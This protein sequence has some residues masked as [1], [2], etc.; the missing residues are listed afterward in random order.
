MY[1]LSTC[2][3]H[4]A[5]LV[6]D[7]SVPYGVI[8]SMLEMCILITSL[9]KILHASTYAMHVVIPLYLT[10]QSS[11]GYPVSSLLL[12]QSHTIGQKF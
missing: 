6:T 8:L 10:I 1:A 3:L 2:T 11:S 4:L 7:N 9:I 5:N 12:I